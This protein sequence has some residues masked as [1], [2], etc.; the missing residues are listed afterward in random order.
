MGQR[1]EGSYTSHNATQQW[2][3]ETRPPPLCLTLMFFKMHA[4]SLKH[5]YKF[6]VKEKITLV[7]SLCDPYMLIHQY[8]QSCKI[9]VLKCEYF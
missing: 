9:T 3:F 4:H 2:P 6:A 1:P 8:Q 5:S 7:T